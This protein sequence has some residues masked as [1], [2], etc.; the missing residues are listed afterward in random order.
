[1]DPIPEEVKRFVEANIDSVDQL[2]ILRILGENPEKEWN[3]VALAR[4]VQTQAQTIGTHLAALQG[5]GLLVVMTRGTD[6]FCRY[7]AG[8]P[9]LENR[10]KQLLQVYR[11]RPVTMI[12]LVYAR[13]KETLK[14]FA[15]AFRLKKES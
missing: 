6:L 4:E 2:E 10:M 11:E 3:A 9:E 15:E 13:A 14:T 7:G 12:N 5:R 8:T 1:M